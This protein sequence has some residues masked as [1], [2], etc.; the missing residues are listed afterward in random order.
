MPGP[1]PGS[2]TM[3]HVSLVVGGRLQSVQESGSIPLCVSPASS[4]GE[5]DGV[6][7]QE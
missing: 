4:K 6:L 1:T 3:T 2:G 7:S 5:D